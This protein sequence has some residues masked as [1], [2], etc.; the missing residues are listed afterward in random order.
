[1]TKK[2]VGDNVF[3]VRR[4]IFCDSIHAIEDAKSQ[5]EI[6]IN[7]IRSSRKFGILMTVDT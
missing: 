1:V 5:G 2:V 6:N 7:L 4:F 3:T